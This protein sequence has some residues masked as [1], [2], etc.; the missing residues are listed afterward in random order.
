MLKL[1]FKPARE[2]NKLVALCNS[3][4]K[5]PMKTMSLSTA[6]PELDIKS[7]TSLADE[8]L[9]IKVKGLSPKQNVTLHAKVVDDS[10]KILE[11]FAFYQGNENGEVDLWTQPSIGGS[12]TGVEPMGLLWSLQSQRIGTL[13]KGNSIT[14]KDVLKP[15]LYDV[16]VFNGHVEPDVEAKPLVSNFFERL[17][18]VKGVKRVMVRDGRIRGTLFLPPGEGSFPGNTELHHFFPKSSNKKG[19][20]PYWH[21]LIYS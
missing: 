9:H 4:L 16:N 12:Y 5:L 13:K 3:L 14:K 8:V 7:Q 2:L 6:T 18:C 15:L 20:C 17:L 1:Y 10:K 11:S 19:Q 21:I